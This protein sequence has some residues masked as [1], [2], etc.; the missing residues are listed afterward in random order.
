MASCLEDGKFTPL[1]DNLIKFPSA[2]SVPPSIIKL[3]QAFWLLDHGDFEDAVTILLDP[4]IK[5]K[6]IL[7]WQHRS[8]LISLLVQD[9]PKLALKYVKIRQPPQ[10]DLFDIQLQ[11][12]SDAPKNDLMLF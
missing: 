10:K 11:V 8:V 12:S 6:D 2:F 4:L 3:T 5:P 7:L 9:Q 1:V